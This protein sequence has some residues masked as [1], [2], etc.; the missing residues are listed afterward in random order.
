MRKVMDVLRLVY[1]A[2][3]SQEEIARSA[4]I[5]QS[6]ISEYLARFRASGLSW[7]LPPELDEATVEARLFRRS[8]LPT[9]GPVRPVPDWAHVHAE[10]KRTGVTLQLLWMEYQRQHEGT[11]ER[12]LCYQY[13]QFCAHYHAWRAQLEPV[14]RQTHVAG[15]RTFVDYA[16]PTVEILDLD[17]GELREAQIFVAALGASHLLY[18]DATWTQQLPD[19]IAS[20]IRMVEYLGGVTALLVPDNLK[21]GVTHASYYEPEIN[22]TYQDFATHYGTVILPTRAVKPRDKAK[23]ETGVLI[24]EREILA[25]LRNHRFTSLAALNEAIAERLE[26]VNDRPF[27]L[28]A[29]SRR[30]VFE[31][32][33]R[34]TLRPLPAERYDFAEWRSA[35]VH[36]DYHIAVEGHFYSVPHALLK[37]TVRVRLTATMV[38]V[39]HHGTRV[40]VHR[41]SVGAASKGRYTTEPA[42]RPKSHQAHLEWTPERLVRWGREIGPATAA[43]VAHILEHKP[44]PEQGYRSCLGLF[45]LAK[46]YTGPRLEAA[47]TRARHTGTMTYRSIKSIL[48]AGL[49]R[50]PIDEPLVLQLPSTHAHVRGAAYYGTATPALPPL[51]LDLFPQTLTGDS[52]C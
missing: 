41:R 3:R 17:T 7:P 34:A 21:S 13:T 19:W 42:H 24:V 32:L 38:E 4:G 49:D 8:A 46:R 25:P 30:S 48:A 43:V 22:A 50:H 9:A 27:Q 2:R 35:T 5:S 40:A 45:S 23:V 44:H 16:G 28:L 15:E 26:L 33:E 37:A 29:G 31:S 52:S 39:L 14:L 1:E 6:T 10:R 11:R 12:E 20:H 18:V 51:P 36:I 47:C